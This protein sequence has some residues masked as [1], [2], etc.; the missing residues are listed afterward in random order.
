VPDTWADADDVLT[1]T[2]VAVDDADLV[3]AQDIIEIF[4]GT[5]YLAND[6]LSP[7]NLRMLNRA[8]AYQAGW[9]SLRPDLYTHLDTDSVSQ[10][11]VTFSPA[12]GNASLLAPLAYRCLRRLTW[13]L[14]PWRVRSGYGTSDYN[15]GP[16]DS[17]VADDAKQWSPL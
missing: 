10:D 2:G 16:R 9:M 4:A 1:Y 13:A 17:A 3:R 12:N 11:G 5:T 15:D 7:R 8:V 6:N 14:K